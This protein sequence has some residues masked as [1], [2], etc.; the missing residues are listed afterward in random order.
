MGKEK[1]KILRTMNNQMVIGTVTKETKNEILVQNPFALIPL[2]EGIRLY[3]LDLELVGRVLEEVPF[4]KRNI[5]YATVPSQVLISEYIKLRDNELQSQSGEGA[6]QDPN[7][8]IDPNGP[9]TDPDN[10]EAKACSTC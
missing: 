7:T 3:P 1:I 8:V 6:S 2:K 4:E 9:I 10:P 5:L